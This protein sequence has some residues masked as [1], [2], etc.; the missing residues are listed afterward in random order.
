MTLRVSWPQALCWRLG[1]QFVHPVGTKPAI[2]VAR[3]LGGVQ[4]QVASS[5][6]L[7]IRLRQQHS[8]PGEV[9]E[10]LADGSLIKTWGMRGTLHLFAADEAGQYLALLAAGRS[11]ESPAWQRYFGLSASQIEGMRDVVR[12]ILDGRVLTR[13]EVNAQIVTASGYEHLGSELKSGW[14]TLFK[15]LAWQGDICFGPS[16]GTR[17]TFA[18]PEQVSPLWRPLPPTEEAARL[19]FLRYFEAYGPATP[20]HV[21][22]WL[23]RGRVSVKQQRAWFATV[24]DEVTKIDVEG[25]EMYVRTKDVDPLAATKVTDSVR[26]L[27]GFD[28]WVLGPGTDDPHL[29]P[30]KRRAAVSRA[31]G[32]IA[33]I[34][35][36]GGVVS[37]TWSTDASRI[38]VEWFN[39]S[40]RPPLAKL[41]SEVDRLAGVLGRPLTLELAVVR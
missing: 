17:V 9:G 28:E 4:A 23:A 22:N 27:G 35:V 39:E 11:W 30:S 15:P 21:R 18:R 13:E 41:E 36:V 32:W 10:A 14:G 33:P 25:E 38:A 7:A 34:V 1:R 20:A 16:R 8:R 6:E 37:G 24:V 29:I 2:D 19:V 3:R 31:A 26:L 40:G 12:G 5:A